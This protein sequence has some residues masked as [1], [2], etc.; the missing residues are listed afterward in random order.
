MVFKITFHDCT[1]ALVRRVQFAEYTFYHQFGP[2]GWYPYHFECKSHT[3]N[4][5][6]EDSATH[7]LLAIAQKESDRLLPN[8]S[9][10]EFNLK[11]LL[12]VVA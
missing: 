5:I 3:G 6:D 2:N 7:R 10:Y 9:L 8:W 4:E 1:G 11:D 12:L